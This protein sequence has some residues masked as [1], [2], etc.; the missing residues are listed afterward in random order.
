MFVYHFFRKIKNVNFNFM[1]SVAH[2]PRSFWA[3]LLFQ[4]SILLLYFARM[5]PWLKLS[6]GALTLGIL[7]PILGT[8]N[9]YYLEV[10]TQVGIFVALALGLNI[11]VGLAGLLD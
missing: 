8:I 4:T 3:F 2:F 9:G 11:V 1:D 10:A 6:L 7:M 5:A